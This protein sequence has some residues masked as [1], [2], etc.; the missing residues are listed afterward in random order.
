GA[1]LTVPSALHI[2]VHMLPDLKSQSNGVA[3]FTASGAI[4]NIFGILIGAVFVTFANWPW[5]LFFITIL[6]LIESALVLLLCHNVRRPKASALDR[7]RRLQKLDVI[8]VA[9]FTGSISGWD[10]AGVIAPLIISVALMTAFL[11]FET[12]IPAEVAVIP[13]VTWSYTNIVVVL[14]MALLPYMW[15]GSV[16]SLLSWYWQEIFG[17]S[18]IITAVHFLPIGISAIPSA[19]L[20]DQLRLKYGFKWLL[21][22]GNLLATIGSILLPFGSS[23]SAYWPIIFPGL[24]IGSF[25]ISMTYTTAN[26]AVFATT[27][28]EAAGV[29]GAMFNSALQLGCAAGIAITTSIQT[30][31][32]Q[33]GDSVTSYKGRADGFWFLVAVTALI[34]ASGL[35]FMKNITQP[36]MVQSEVHGKDDISSVKDEVN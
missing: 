20:A 36:P 17:W 10:S 21:A 31:I 27:P 2:I 1:A 33:Q 3:I 4:G 15:W 11:F 35:V 34:G 9:C 14:T 25:G 32:Q 18:P 28:P 26:V 12:R 5:I 16:Q 22:C 19:V 30:S 6:A 7:M 29:I 13:P 24:V 8:G 23:H